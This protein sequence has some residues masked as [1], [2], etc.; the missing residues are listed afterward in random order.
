M[1]EQLTLEKIDPFTG[2][3]RQSARDRPRSAVKRA[4]ADSLIGLGENLPSRTVDF[5]TAQDNFRTKIYTMMAKLN[6]IYEFKQIF[7]IFSH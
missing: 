5:Y 4:V 3:K 6:A 2:S 1:T 7:N